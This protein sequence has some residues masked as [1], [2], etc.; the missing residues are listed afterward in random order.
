MV[1]EDGYTP[2][3]TATKN[4]DGSVTI[5]TVNESGKD[6][7]TIPAGQD[8]VSSY[9]HVKYSND[10]GKTFTDN[11]GEDPG[12]YIAILQNNTEKDPDNISAYTGLW[13]KITGEDGTKLVSSVVQYATSTDGQNPPASWGKENV[14]PSVSSGQYLWTRTANTYD[15]APNDPIYIYSVSYKPK[16][17]T[18]TSTVIKYADGG[19]NGSTAPTS[20]WQDTAPAVD[21]G[22]YL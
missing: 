2:T 22:H 7:K 17:L 12:D 21:E 20:G 14:I 3:V 18:K 5:T 9:L 13:K 4:S 10:N 15:N 8:G 1:G 19:T 11:N 6:T 16:E